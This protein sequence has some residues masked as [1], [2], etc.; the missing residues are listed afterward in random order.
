MGVNLDKIKY[1]N[2]VY[3]E[4]DNKGKEIKLIE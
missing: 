2:N 3:V 4:P 1:K